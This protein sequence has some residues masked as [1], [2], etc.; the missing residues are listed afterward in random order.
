[1]RAGWLAVGLIAL[2]AIALA[3]PD[4]GQLAASCASCHGGA[5]AAGIARLADLDAAQVVQ[6]MLSYRRGERRSQIM[7]VVAAALSPD[8]IMAVAAYLARPPGDRP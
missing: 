7:R 4:G 2:P 1:M 3:G 6:A 5:G 8:E